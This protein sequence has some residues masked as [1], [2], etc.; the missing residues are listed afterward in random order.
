MTNPEYPRPQPE[1]VIL[2]EPGEPG[3]EHHP[4]VWLSSPAADDDPHPPGEWLCTAHPPEQITAVIADLH[5]TGHL[6]TGVT[7]QDAVG[8]GAWQPRP[9]DPIAAVCTVGRG[10]AQHGPAYAAWAVLTGGLEILNGFTDYY[11]GSFPNR[12]A[13]AEATYGDEIEQHLAAVLKPGL[14]D[15]III[16]HDA[17]AG[18]A[19][20]CEQV[21]FYPDR[22]SVHAFRVDPQP[23]P[24]RTGP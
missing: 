4:C 9:D 8:F 14:R 13:W 11:L 7:V 1:D 21:C 22:G 12:A 20:E 23:A 5:A 10:I 17:L 24:R 19:E 18:Y 2:T 3:H 15:F 16:G 6:P